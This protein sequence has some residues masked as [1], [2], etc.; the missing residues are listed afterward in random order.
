VV[1]HARAS[2]SKPNAGPP[3]WGTHYGKGLRPFD[4]AASSRVR[5]NRIEAAKSVASQT[6]KG[7]TMSND[8]NTKTRPTHR[9]YSVTKNGDSK[10]NWQEIG[11]AWPHK[12]GMGFSLKFTARALDGA[13]IVLRTPKVGKEAA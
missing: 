11:A 4:R 1:L 5:A 2:P 13:E 10:A 12:D 7:N 6:R 8:T 3:L 9:I